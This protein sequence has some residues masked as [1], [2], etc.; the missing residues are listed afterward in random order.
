LL[1]VLPGQTIPTPLPLCPSLRAQPCRSFVA[2]T[3]TPAP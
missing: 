3:N 1:P 2:F